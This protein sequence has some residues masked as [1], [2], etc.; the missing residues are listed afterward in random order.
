MSYLAD[1]TIPLGYLKDQ[2]KPTEYIDKIKNG[3]MI[4]HLSAISVAEIYHGERRGHPERL[5]RI[6]NLLTYFKREEVTHEIAQEAGYICS[7][8]V[9]GKKD[10]EDKNP[11][12]DAI[13]AAT[14]KLKKLVLVTENKKHFGPLIEKGFISG[15]IYL[16]E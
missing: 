3:E 12:F 6:V 10:G 9:M 11:L 15:V 4:F 14:A 16:K 13:I 7:E 1:T 5:L 2:P 8:F